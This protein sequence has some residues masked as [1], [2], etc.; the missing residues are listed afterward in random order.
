MRYYIARV[1]GQ[2]DQEGHL[3]SHQ[4]DVQMYGLRL[5]M[6]NKKKTPGKKA[7]IIRRSES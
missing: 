3:I 6:L 1:D 4:G 5:E 7:V 2:R